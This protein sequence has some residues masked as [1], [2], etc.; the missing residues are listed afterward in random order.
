MGPF[1]NIEPA[2]IG[3]GSNINFLTVAAMVA[4]TGL[5]LGDFVSVEDY[6]T[7]NNSG[8][9]FFKVVA[10]G[11]GTADGGSFIDLP[12]TTPALQA[13]QNF[14]PQITV[15]MF[16]AK[17][18]DSTDDTTA[19]V[20]AD[21]AAIDT[22]LIWPSGAYIHTAQI[23]IKSHWIAQSRDSVTLKAQGADAT[24]FQSLGTELT[25][26]QV[27]WGNGAGG[28]TK[29]IH[30]INF[31]TDGIEDLSNV[32]ESSIGAG[33]FIGGNS[34]ARFVHCRFTAPNDN[35]SH[36]STLGYSIHFDD[37]AGTLNGILVGAQFENCLWEDTP[38]C[39]H[40]NTTTDDI[41][42][43]NCRFLNTG[44]A[45]KSSRWPIFIAA[46]ANVT[47][48]TY[49]MN[50]TNYDTVN[51]TSD[52]ESWIFCGAFGPHMFKG[53]F[54]EDIS[55]GNTADTNNFKWIWAFGSN[56]QCIDSID[57][58]TV[59]WGSTDLRA[60]ISVTEANSTNTTFTRD[61]SFK[62]ITCRTNLSNNIVP[63]S[64]MDIFMSTE[65][66][67]FDKYN[68][69]FDN[70][71]VFP[72]LYT[73]NNDSSLT[74]VDGVDGPKLIGT[75]RGKRYNSTTKSATGKAITG[76]TQANPCVITATSHGYVEADT[77]DKIYITD[78]AGM[79]ELNDLAY[80]MTY[81]DANSFSI[82]VDSSAFTA[83]TSGGFSTRIQ[84]YPTDLETVWVDSGSFRISS[85]GAGTPTEA[86]YGSTRYR[87][88][89][90]GNG[91]VMALTANVGIN[92][93]R[94]SKWIAKIYWTNLAGGSGNVAWQIFGLATASG[95][96]VDAA[97]TGWTEIVAALGD[98][99]LNIT[100]DAQTQEIVWRQGELL[101]LRVIRD[102]TSD[103]LANAVGLI[104]VML[105]PVTP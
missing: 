76:A 64:L 67:G 80:T 95:D 18:D 29:L 86:D 92:T 16:G 88:W 61:L 99:V 15:K 13:K 27:R 104:G 77:G 41:K 96:S 62:N 53:G 54:V 74:T 25:P 70:V 17:G 94:C 83:Y 20:N 98:D 33:A 91:S 84:D 42:F 48:D 75:H 59:N 58:L 28:K 47:F 85:A 30:G 63:P 100:P 55:V 21:A 5:A 9:L 23:V 4:D 68:I 7:G 90:M 81:V 89:S 14:P 102:T 12:N 3:S 105:E 22:A 32:A 78:V 24:G 19:L 73:W 45:L 43:Q 56:A 36:S 35:G 40:L 97:G 8:V 1:D 44:T 52:R 101:S 82:G 103:T 2:L 65:N 37:N 6:A 57:G 38:R 50:F 69:T 93:N 66:A 34:N 71:D 87:C 72:N 11:T 31:T 79:V 49:Y 60:L 51:W 46:N 10:A 26:A 39:L